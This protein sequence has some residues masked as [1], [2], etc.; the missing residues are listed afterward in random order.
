MSESL[1]ARSKMVI[2]QLHYDNG[3]EQ[4]YIYM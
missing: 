3:Y 1:G 4:G 2:V